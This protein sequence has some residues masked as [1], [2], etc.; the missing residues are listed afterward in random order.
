MSD[1]VSYWYIWPDTQYKPCHNNSSWHDKVI[2]YI[3]IWLKTALENINFCTYSN[4]NWTTI[5]YQLGCGEVLWL[6]L[7]D[8]ATAV[9]CRSSLE[10]WGQG[11]ANHSHPR[12]NRR[13][14]QWGCHDT[15]HSLI[16]SNPLT[17]SN[18][19]PLKAIR[20]QLK[21]HSLAASLTN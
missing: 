1:W 13:P 17:H 18:P 3:I 8:T 21:G 2:Q 14:P 20:C 6:Y 19:D 11:V 5:I 15:G 9:W 12:S 7:I 4:E 16:A 10:P